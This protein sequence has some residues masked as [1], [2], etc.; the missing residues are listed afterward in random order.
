MK[1]L[2]SKGKA[3]YGMQKLHIPQAKSGLLWSAIQVFQLYFVA[4]YQSTIHHLT[5]PTC[6]LVTLLPFQLTLSFR[7]TTVCTNHTFHIPQDAKSGL[8][9]S[10]IQ[11]FQL[12]FVAHYLSTIHHLSRPT[13]QLVTSSTISAHT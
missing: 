12:Y 10:A 2:P 13:C 7:R 5:R 3:N 6:Q 9:W 8:L 1:C 4:H 11:V